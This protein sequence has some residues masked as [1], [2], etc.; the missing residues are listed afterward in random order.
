MTNQD[1]IAKAT[2]ALAESIDSIVELDR[3]SAAALSETFE[4]FR[5][6][7]AKSSDN[8]EG[9]DHHASKVADLLVESGSFE[10]R[11][12]ALAHLLHHKNGAALLRRERAHRR[13]APTTS[14]AF[15]R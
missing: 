2:S 8:G 4:Q 11:K 10:T 14:F 1:I 5:D 6:Y 12:A 15:P 3:D 13:P 7:M 9:G